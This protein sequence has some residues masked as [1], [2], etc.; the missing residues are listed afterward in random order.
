MTPAL[1]EEGAILARFVAYVDAFAKPR[2]QHRH[3]KRMPDGLMTMREAAAKLGC[4]VKTLKGHIACGALR[5]VIIGHGTKRPHKRITPADLNAF[6]EAQ[7]RKDV[8][9]P[10]TAS[11]RSPYWQFDFQWRGHRFHGST[12]GTTRREAEKVEA[13]EREKAKRHVAQTEAARTSMR[14]DDIAGRYWQEHA[15]HLAGAA[16]AEGNLALLIEFFGKDKLI[17][18]IH[19][20]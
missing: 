6:I 16:N 12:K 11:P 19:R 2:R 18:D 3:R 1:S 14:L 13:A 4:S 9:C 5:Y 20:R 15:Q 8:A 10:S 17:T 7:T